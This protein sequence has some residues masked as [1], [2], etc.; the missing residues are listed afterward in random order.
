MKSGDDLAP[1]KDSQLNA[2]ETPAGPGENAPNASDQKDGAVLHGEQAAMQADKE[3]AE[4]GEISE[5]AVVQSQHK[6]PPQ[7]V[8]PISNDP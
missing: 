1:R 2:V 6:S 4:E 8:R 3:E 5:D 7:T